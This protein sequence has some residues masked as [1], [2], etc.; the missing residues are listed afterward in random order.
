MHIFFFDAHYFLNCNT[1]IEIIQLMFRNETRAY[2]ELQELQRKQ[3]P[4]LISLVSLSGSSWSNS[5]DIVDNDLL[6][7]NGFSL[8]MFP[9]QR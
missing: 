4:G 5:D 2:R 7:G 8:N 1:R 9:G 3:I 6:R